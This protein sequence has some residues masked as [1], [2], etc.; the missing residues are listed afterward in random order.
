MGLGGL[1]VGCLRNSVDI[2]DGIPKEATLMFCRGCDRFLSPPQTW[3]GAQP[4]SR[5][6][7]GEWLRLDLIRPTSGRS[8]S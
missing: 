2:T 4:E 3:V 5:E 8:E 1:G 6:L 7:L